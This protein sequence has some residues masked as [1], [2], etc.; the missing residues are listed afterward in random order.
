MQ[1]KIIGW[2]YAILVITIA[3]L[4]LI[5]VLLFAWHIED[6]TPW[7]DMKAADWGVWVGAV[8]TVAT[9]AMTVW[10]ATSEQRRRTR[11]E[12]DLALV[13]VAG[14]T[15]RISIVKNGMDGIGAVL[16]SDMTNNRATNYTRVSAMLAQL[17]TWKPE[18]LV[19]LVGV[20]DH[21]AARLAF[22]AAEIEGVRTAIDMSV[23]VSLYTDPT[24][25]RMFN[26]ITLPRI[27]A[28]VEVLVD[29]LARCRRYM[30]ESGFSEQ[31]PMTDP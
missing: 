19:A 14:L 2:A 24:V 7:A 17:P 10:L 12:R 23:D 11:A 6:A 9:L 28:P 15:F 3:L 31:S 1:K 27:N 30:D 25:S 21:L 16:L 29:C 8:G 5:G 18:E 22:A 4:A 26:A 13:T 20:H